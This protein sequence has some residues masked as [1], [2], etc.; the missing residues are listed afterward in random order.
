M[1]KIPIISEDIDTFDEFIEEQKTNQNKF[2][3]DISYALKE[4]EK[5]EKEGR[6]SREMTYEEFLKD[7][8]NDNEY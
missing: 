3:F 1:S 4:S 6:I 7:M 8:K 5:D 2:N